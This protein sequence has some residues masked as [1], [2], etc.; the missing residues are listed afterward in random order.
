MMSYR[1]EVSSRLWMLRGEGREKTIAW[2]ENKAWAER[3][4]Y[5]RDAEYMSCVKDIMDSPVFQSMDRYIQHGNTTTKTHCIQVSYLSYC[6]CKKHSLDYVTAARAG[7][8]HDLFLYDWH[9]AGNH[10]H[11]FTHPRVAMRNARK[12]FD[13]TPQEQNII[14]R[15]MW[16]LTPIPPRSAE[17]MVIVYADK[18]CS[19]NE[20]YGR[21]KRA[22]YRAV[23][24]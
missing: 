12:Y 6:I 8:L 11:G 9:T 22:V 13:L 17:G 10:I 15:H 20:V 14:L 2:L 23:H 21:M 5:S 3:G 7:L 19:V 18:F 1:K 4:E 16:P 24:A